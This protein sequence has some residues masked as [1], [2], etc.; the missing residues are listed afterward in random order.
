MTLA[1]DLDNSSLTTTIKCADCGRSLVE[2]V[3]SHDSDKLQKIIAHCGGGTGCGGESWVMPLSG[4]YSMRPF[5]ERSITDMD[6]NEDGTSHL[7]V[8]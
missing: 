2:M 3:K 6:Y 7:H 8:S 5:G 1:D 4:E